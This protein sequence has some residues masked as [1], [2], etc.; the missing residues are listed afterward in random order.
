MYFISVYME[1]VYEARHLTIQ[2]ASRIRPN[3]VASL[4]IEFP[5]TCLKLTPSLRFC[6]YRGH[7]VA[8]L[9]EALLQAGRSQ[10][11]FP[12]VSLEFFIDIILPTALCPLGQIS[13]SQKWVPGI[14]PGSKCGRCVELTTLPPSCADCLEIR[15]PQ[16]P[17]TLRACPDL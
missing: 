15:E 3:I 11:R 10:V 1:R 9:V 7:A 14:F 17:G 8:Q 2:I 13:L 16:P 5:S 4:M 6:L 12:M